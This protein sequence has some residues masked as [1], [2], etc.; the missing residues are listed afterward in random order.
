LQAA[1]GQNPQ[2]LA[3]AGMKHI[4]I[5]AEDWKDVQFLPD[6]VQVRVQYT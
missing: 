2:L 4:V 1:L 3:A 5:C 6:G